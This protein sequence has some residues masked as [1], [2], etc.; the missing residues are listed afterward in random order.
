MQG[1]RSSLPPSTV[2]CYIFAFSLGA[3]IYPMIEIL[4]RSYTHFTMVILGGICGIIIYRIH[5]TL[6][7]DGYFTK[8]LMC[9]IIITISEFFAGVFLNIILE[10]RIW[11]YSDMPFHLMGQ[12]SLP[13]SLIWFFISLP[14]LYLCR[15][16]DQF[17]APYLE[18]NIFFINNKER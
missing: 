2:R 8:A 17:L 11:D 14:S 16:I 9:S 6:R 5:R 7:H 15:L 18:G 1:L 10:L 4:Y 13:F 12:I 3:V